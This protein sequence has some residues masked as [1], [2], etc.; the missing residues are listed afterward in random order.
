[1][2]LTFKLNNYGYIMETLT[3]GTIM[4]FCLKFE[5]ELENVYTMGV[6]FK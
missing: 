1:M 5:E 4:I 6:V 3:P 2:I